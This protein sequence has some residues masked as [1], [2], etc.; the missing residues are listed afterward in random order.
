METIQLSG[1]TTLEKRH[2]ATRHL[3]PKQITTNGLNPENV[4]MN[5]DVID[6][7]I[8][9]Y[10]RESGVRNLERELG[11]VCRSKAV[12]FAEAK[13]TNTIPA[14]SPAVSVDDL[15]DILGIERFDEELAATTAQPGVVTGLVAYASGTQGSILFIEVA[16][17]PGAGRVQLTGKLGDVLKESVE[18]AL[19][20]VKSHA[21]ELALTHDPSEDI[22]KSRAIHVHCPSGAIPKDGPSAG[23]AHTIA[24][25]SLFSGKTVPPHLA[26]TGEVA[27]RGKVMPVG[28]IKEKLIG[29]LRAGVKKVLLPQ[30]NRKEVK[31]LPEE[32]KEGL[33]IVLV[34]HIWEALPHAG[35]LAGTT[36]DTTLFPLDTLKTRLQSAAGFFPSGGFRGV[37]NGIGS[38]VVGSAPGAALFFVTYEGVKAHFGTAD[39][40][41]GTHMLAA[42]LGEVAACAVRVPTE[43]VKQRAQAGQHA[44]S[45]EALASILRLRREHGVSRVWGELYRGWSITVFREVPFTVIQF[46]LWEGM[47]RYALQ[48]RQ[49]LNPTAFVTDPTALQ[50]GAAESALY[51]SLSGAIAAGLTTP[52][53]VLKTRMMLARERQSVAALASRIWRDEGSRAF[54]AGVGPRTI[55]ISIGG[56][57]FL[58]SYQWASNLLAGR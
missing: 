4:Q 17:M 20:W 33:E 58:G 47:K 56:A 45:R 14:Y 30:Q 24:L 32:V 22:M 31:D 43:V 7:V 25:I 5:E 36:V 35:G 2:I 51:G 27:L 55:W 28:G 38:A 6:K 34:G 39:V 49:H 50:T 11:S 3:I 10:T 19:S 54:F 57:V 41:A 23:L 44:S 1:Y 12:Q 40:G 21:Y 26:M 15:E 53:D 52:L 9:S 13:D 16:D 48:R 29:A 18:V 46:P 8:T 37:Y 42:S